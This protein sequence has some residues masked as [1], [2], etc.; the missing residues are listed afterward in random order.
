[1]RRFESIGGVLLAV[2]LVLA[3][4]DDDGDDMDAGR[5]G[6]MRMDAAMTD[7]GMD[8]EAPG[9]GGVDGGPEDGGDMD[10][11][12]DAAM[13]DAGPVG[14]GAATSAQ[15]QAVIDAA[16]GPTDLAID[17]AIVTY[18]K[19][20]I[21]GDDAGFF[22]QAEPM[23]PALF[24]RVDPS[25]L[26]PSPEVGDVVDLHVTDITTLQG[27]REVVMIASGS[28]NVDSSGHDVS[29]LV[30]EVSSVDLVTMIDDFQMELV[31]VTFDPRGLFRPAGTGFQKISVDTAA[32]MDEDAIT[33]RLP[34]ALADSVGFEEGCRYTITG[35]P[36]WRLDTEVQISAFDASEIA[37]ADC[38]TPAVT[39]GTTL[40]ERTA[41]VYF[42]RVIDPASVM[43]DGSQFTIVD[44]TTASVTV[45][46]AM[47]VA[48]ERFVIV[49]TSADMLA[50]TFYT[51]TVAATVEDTA[52]GGVDATMNDTTFSGYTPHLVIN[53]VDYDQAGTDAGE[54][55]EIFNPGRSAVSLTG[56][57]LYTINGM[58]GTMVNAMVDL[59]SNSD[60]LTSLPAGGDMVVLTTGSTAV[61]V[62]A[63]VA[64]IDLGTTLQNDQEGVVLR[65]TGGAGACHDA[66][67]YEAIPTAA[68]FMGCAYE[69]S[70]GIDPGDGWLSRIPNGVD[71]QENAL[72]F[73]VVMPTPG[74]ANVP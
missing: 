57:T 62:P 60:S 51:V 8:A 19:A 17:D 25:T 54:F 42:N 48:G 45:T 24:V 72:D 68:T 38:D 1:M 70:A 3:G 65:G 18:L 64:T 41:V 35:T 9:D 74:A 30:Q 58:A 44:S 56:I 66:V 27:R 10:G 34:D 32:L 13:D 36:L 33:V 21:G 52:G 61:T 11:G 22:L 26:T 43:A 53:E 39:L 23:G 14:G 15:I 16:D 28:W 4:C 40:N 7:A 50:P 49:G 29:F 12:T 47:A 69:S 63:G 71:T 6:G 67:F 20:D 31:T 2:L 46:S 37:R 73:R 55:I 59:T 5:D